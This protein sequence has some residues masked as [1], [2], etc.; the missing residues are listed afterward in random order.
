MNHILVLFGTVVAVACVTIA[1]AA[2]DDCKIDYLAN[3]TKS[4]KEYIAEG[5]YSVRCDNLSLTEVPKDYPDPPTNKSLCFLD[6]SWNNFDQL[7]NNSFVNAANLNTSLIRNLYLDNSNISYISSNAFLGLSGLLY[8]N[9]SGNNLI[10]PS[11]FGKGIFKPLSNLTYLNIK[12]NNL[13]TFEGLGV[14]LGYT[15]LGG[16][17]AELCANCT[18]GKEFEQLEHLVNLSLSGRSKGACNV[19]VVHNNTFEGLTKLQRLWL[20]SCNIREIEANTFNP[21][22][23]SLILLDISYNEKMNFTRMNTALYGLRNSSKLEVLNV[24][25]IHNVHDLGV[26]V[27]K[28]DLENL[29]TLRSLIT[30]HMDLNKIEIFDEEIFDPIFMFPSSLRDLTLSGNRLSFGKYINFIHNATNITCLDISRQHLYYDPF[31]YEHFEPENIQEDSKTANKCMQYEPSEFPNDTCNDSCSICIPPNLHRIKWRKSFLNFNTEMTLNICGANNL[32]HLDLSFNLLTEWKGS[33]KG[34]EH[35]K[36]LDLSENYCSE[37]A[38]AFF[39]N[40]RQLKHLNISGNI[41]GVSFGQT[42][43][44]NLSN[45]IFRN[46]TQITVLDLSNNRIE[47][48]SDKQIFKDLRNIEV[49]YLHSN[50]MG[51]WEYVMPESKSLKLLDLSRNKLS[52]LSEKLRAY[53]DRL[54]QGTLCNVSLILENNPLECSCKT[55]SFL[56]WMLSTKV[57]VERDECRFNTEQRNIS[58]NE[59]LHAMIETL[60]KKEYLDRSW[61][62]WTVGI[63]CAIVGCFTSIVIGVVVYKYRWKLRYLYYSRNRRFNHEGFERLF[64][65][66]AFVSYSKCKASFIKN[67]MVPSLEEQRG[68]RLW[69]TDRNSIPG[70]SIA[71]TITHGIYNSRKSVLLIDT[72]YLKDSW[73]DYE[74][75]MVHVES[76]E[77]RRK[78]IIIVLMENIPLENLPINV[79][80]FLRSER[81]L[82]Y[83]E[84]GHDL[85]VFWT[86]LADEIMS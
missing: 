84:H 21:L 83:P 1:Q 51:D 52:T 63:I 72:D 14:E 12:E 86:N 77:A 11:G 66:D 6:L 31:L 24:N 26:A 43:S 53:L 64:E 65:N 68:L 60:E 19:S 54:C 69:V 39:D 33:I 34:L 18:F 74:M 42:S 62:T 49:M 75:N 76:T 70:T 71:E 79:M 28:R 35:L 16:I 38:P 47:R 29:S 80:R 57:V 36:H 44:F 4:S 8:L 13:Q 7:K 2:A 45:N 82:E 15:K 10:W 30:L 85:D 41:L 56:K 58:E 40:F 5:C 59:A 81:S 50:L 23:K 46:L 37:V 61:Q 25:R 67:K 27:K 73:C 17:Y 32:S 3:Q 48:F 78:L 20:S 55:L 9:L 22:N